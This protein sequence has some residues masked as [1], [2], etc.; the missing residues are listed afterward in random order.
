MASNLHSCP[1][2][3][4]YIASIQSFVEAAGLRALYE[5]ELSAINTIASDNNLRIGSFDLS[6]LRGF[7]CIDWM[8][9]AINTYDW[10]GGAPYYV[11]ARS[12]QGLTELKDRLAAE[13]NKVA[14]DRAEFQL[15]GAVGVDG[16]TPTRTL[17]ERQVRTVLDMAD[18]SLLLASTIASIVLLRP[19]LKN[20]K[21]PLGGIG[22][23]LYQINVT[24]G[25]SMSK[26]VDHLIQLSTVRYERI[27]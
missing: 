17:N 12:W 16:V 8:C 23:N 24:T 27:Q 15:S 9:G 25:S 10:G 11:P 19:Y 20:Q 1:I 18:R 22:R 2:I 3:H 14:L 13:E 21:G 6:C 4:T 5:N 26:M 7:M